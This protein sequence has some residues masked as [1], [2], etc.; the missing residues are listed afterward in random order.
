MVD[1]IVLYVRWGPQVYFVRFV[2]LLHACAASFP[3]VDDGDGFFPLLL[4]LLRG[5]TSIKY[6]CYLGVLHCLFFANFILC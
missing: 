4:M 1:F 6:P 2:L 3:F 5:E